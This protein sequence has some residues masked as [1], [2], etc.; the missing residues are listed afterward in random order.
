MDEII[1]HELAI[2]GVED[3]VSHFK[4]NE[5]ITTGDQHLLLNRAHLTL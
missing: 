1:F 4:N 3:N 2:F 5:L